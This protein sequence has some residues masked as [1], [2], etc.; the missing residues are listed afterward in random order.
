M[1]LSSSQLILPFVL[2]LRELDFK[3]VG[4]RKWEDSSVE[5]AWRTKL[6]LSEPML[7][8]KIRVCMTLIT[9]LEGIPRAHWTGQLVCPDW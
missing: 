5:Q 2:I 9:V 6:N 8:K 4:V 7:K 3:K 1:K